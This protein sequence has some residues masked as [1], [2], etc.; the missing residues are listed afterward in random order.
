[1]NA[2]LPIQLE[3]GLYLDSNEAHEYGGRLVSAY[4]AAEPFPH[5]VLDDFLPPAFAAEVLEHFP[6]EDRAND[7]HYEMGYAGLHKR[8]ILP[9]DCDE[10][11]GCP[12]VC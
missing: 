2:Q 11:C 1:L 6:D 8:Q 10:F 3:K 12:E 4:R 7:E 5:I 9:Y